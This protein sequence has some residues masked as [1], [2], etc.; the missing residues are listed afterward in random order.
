MGRLRNPE[1]HSTRPQAEALQDRGRVSLPQ[2]VFLLGTFF[3]MGLMLVI[4]ELW[5]L[6]ED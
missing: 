1:L 3:G 5:G 4:L 2:I 6:G